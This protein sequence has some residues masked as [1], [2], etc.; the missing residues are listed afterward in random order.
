MRTTW[1]GAVMASLALTTGSAAVLAAGPAHA[2][3]ATTPVNVELQLGGS[4]DI[5]ATYKK[6]IGSFQASIFYV[7]D[8]TQ[9]SVTA[10][11]AALQRK[12]PGK[13]WHDVRIDNSA[14]TVGFGTYGSHATGNMQYRLH[15]LGGTD[16]TTTWAP[17]FSNVVSVS[18]L[19]NLH[20][21]A[22]CV[23]G[24]RL[25]G[26]LSP[27][28]KHQKITIEIMHSD[29]TWHPY[30]VVH[31]DSRSRWRATVKA[32]R[33]GRFYQPV[34]SSSKHETTTIGLGYRFARGPGLRNPP[35]TSR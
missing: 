32:T 5:A 21:Q 25:F 22:S 6:Q 18:T 4:S 3:A 16:G 34:A 2:G 31:T 17:G 12:L 24:C 14:S 20:E 27:K 7:S 19:W 23:G 1:L 35:V 8:S 11:K 33:A 13:H 10:G 30:K 28:A 9:F 26:K 29:G 15:Y